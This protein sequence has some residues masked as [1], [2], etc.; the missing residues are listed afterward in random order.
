MIRIKKILEYRD[1]LKYILLAC[2]KHKDSQD[3]III[4][5]VIQS[6]MSMLLYSLKKHYKYFIIVGHPTTLRYCRKVF[7]NSEY[8]KRVSYLHK[9]DLS[10]YKKAAIIS[11]N[12]KNDCD[13]WV[14]LDY[15]NKDIRKLLDCQ[16]EKTNDVNN[17]IV[18]PYYRAPARFYHNYIGK[19]SD[20]K[21]VNCR[22]FFAGTIP[23]EGYPNLAEAFPELLNRTIII[24]HIKDEY[25]SNIVRYEDV[26][27]G[28]YNNITFNNMFKP[29]ILIALNDKRIPNSKYY[30]S[31]NDFEEQL[32]VSDFFIAPPGNGM[33]HCHNIM[34][35][36]SRG[37]VPITNYANWFYPKLEDG[38]NCLSFNTLDEL[39]RAIQKSLS[40]TES[41]VIKMRRN[42]KDYYNKYCSPDMTY[43]M[44]NKHFGSRKRIM[45]LTNDEGNSI[46]FQKEKNG[47]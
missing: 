8:C 1:L 9:T 40:M 33:P 41:E 24:D 39:N 5:A 35:A 14:N 11:D 16:N 43:E 37:S 32:A 18:F 31:F 20:F 27:N 22:I 17:L 28:K 38:V 34:E 44:L 30:I 45:M 12:D 6:G 3:T 26:I 10:K 15:Y 29:D 23:V 21:G 42:V 25:S 36:M 19:N 13:I 4:N 7:T 47:K 46:R 2:G